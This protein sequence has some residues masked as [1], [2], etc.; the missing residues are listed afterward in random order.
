METLDS[1]PCTD[2][3]VNNGRPLSSA[4]PHY[5]P[6]R[7]ASYS[8]RD[9]TRPHQPALLLPT[10]LIPTRRSSSSGYYQQHFHH[11]ET[12]EEAFD[13]FPASPE[14]IMRLPS[15]SFNSEIPGHP[16]RSFTFPEAARDSISSSGN[17]SCRRSNSAPQTRYR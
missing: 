13:S 14:E 15:G 7:Q 1:I 17:P 4:S 12:I 9:Y 5:S 16:G 6:Q 10:S 11:Y 8:E 3:Y 2:R